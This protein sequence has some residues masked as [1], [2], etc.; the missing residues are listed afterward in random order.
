VEEAV[1]TNQVLV[2]LAEETVQPVLVTTPPEAAAVAA[3]AATTQQQVQTLLVE[4]A[5]QVLQAALLALRW[6]T[7][8]E[9]AVLEFRQEALA[10]M[11]EVTER[12]DHRTMAQTLP[13]MAVA[14]AADSLTVEMGALELSS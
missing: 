2:G 4:P 11:A 10:P 12:P 7:E 14:V 8:A 1:A 6:A 3:Q 9:A 13:I 5:E